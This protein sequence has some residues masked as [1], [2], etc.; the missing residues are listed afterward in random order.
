MA[1][2]LIP[3]DVFVAGAERLPEPLYRAVAD[4]LALGEAISA[5]CR[6]SL[7]DTA[8]DGWSVHRLVQAVVRERLSPEESPAYAAAA[9]QSV[10][11]TSPFESGNVTTWI[12]CTRLLPHGLAFV[13]HAERIEATQ[14]ACGRLL[15]QMG[16][17][18]RG[19]AD[20]AG[21]KSLFCRALTIAEATY[22][23]DHP[24]VATALNNLGSVMRETGD[25]AGG[26]LP[27][28]AGYRRGGLLPGPPRCRRQSQQLGRRPL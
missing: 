28:G 14:E 12:S 3:Q 5:L 9:V 21:A 6:Y 11:A 17:Y 8:D 2:D 27:A 24:Y 20:F 7:I 16:L 19:R 1:S 23:P 4:P 13:G 15:N 22:G 18:L 25:L 26:T 10:N